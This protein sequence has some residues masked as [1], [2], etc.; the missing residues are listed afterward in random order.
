MT[1]IF[2]T[3]EP[4][5]LLEISFE[6]KI[7]PGDPGNVSGLPENCY[8]PE[9]PE[10]ELMKDSFEQDLKE[11]LTLLEAEARAW[12]QSLF[13]DI[14]ALDKEVLER[15]E[16]EWEADQEDEAHEFEHACLSCG[17]SPCL[18]RDY[19]WDEC[20]PARFPDD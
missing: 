17:A 13:D 19:E 12:H 5:A 16:E 2:K 18:C 1:T 4:E 20:S 9:A 10:P 14:K 15:A 11:Y 8:P 7:H 6:F 3:F